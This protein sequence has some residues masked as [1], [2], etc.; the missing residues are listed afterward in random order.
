MGEVDSAALED[1]D[2]R[3]E[4]WRAALGLGSFAGVQGLAPLASTQGQ[5]AF[6]TSALEVER[7]QERGCVHHSPQSGPRASTIPAIP[8]MQ[9]LSLCL[10][11][12][13][14]EELDDLGMELQELGA[15]IEAMEG[16]IR[17]LLRRPK[18]LPML[19]WLMQAGLVLPVSLQGC[20]AFE[21]WKEE[22][23]AKTKARLAIENGRPQDG[24]EGTGASSRSDTSKGMSLPPIMPH[25]VD[26]VPLLS[27]QPRPCGPAW[28][29]AALLSQ[30]MPATFPPPRRLTSAQAIRIAI[31]AAVDKLHVETAEAEASVRAVELGLSPA[32]ARKY[33]LSRGGANSDKKAE[34]VAAASASRAEQAAAGLSG[35]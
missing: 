29:C 16:H 13:P 34:I 3:R 22:Q 5:G 33:L 30:H 9:L 25:D 18:Y 10:H 4:A 1:E 28:I 27:A 7:M 19:Q 17:T 6:A 14:A 21:A 11:E 24:K 35:R 20:I 2:N 15:E 31:S 12:A 26:L 32:E 8:K 23:R